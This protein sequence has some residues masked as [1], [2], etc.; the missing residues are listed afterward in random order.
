VLIER[1]PQFQADIARRMD[2]VLAGPASRKGRQR[3]GARER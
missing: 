3:Q 2:L 1:E